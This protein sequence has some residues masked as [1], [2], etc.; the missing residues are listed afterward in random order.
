[1]AFQNKKIR[2]THDLVELYSIIDNE[3]SLSEENIDILDIAT[4]YYSNNR[5]PHSNYTLPKDEEIQKVIDSA[6]VI[7]GKVQEI[8][9]R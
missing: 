8:C 7:Y 3:L 9:S 4:T 1:M 5:Y 6:G 2:K